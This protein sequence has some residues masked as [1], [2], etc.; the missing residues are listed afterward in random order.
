MTDTTFRS[1]LIKK[2]LEY[3]HDSLSKDL[4]LDDLILVINDFIYASVSVVHNKLSIHPVCLVNAVKNIIGENKNKP[5]KELLFFTLNYLF[6]HDFRIN[7]QDILDKV[8]EK[9]QRPIACMADLENACQNQ[10]WLEAELI[11][12]QI[13][14]ASDGSRAI[15]DL[16]AELALQNIPQNVLVVYHILRAYQ[17]QENKSDN[18]AFAKTMFNQ[19]S[20]Q[21][22]LNPHDRTD[23]T[24][25]KINPLML[26]SDDIILYSAISRIWSGDYVRISGYKRELSYWMS[27]IFANK[28]SKKKLSRYKNTSPSNSMSYSSIAEKIIHQKKSMDGKAID[29]VKLESIRGLSSLLTPDQ[30][31][32]LNKKYN[33]F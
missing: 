28:L 25:E 9:G 14:I 32:K 7:D 24:P 8:I 31:N 33:S 21:I 11:M 16:L 22:L 13:Y 15:F 5:S 1:N 30:I 23:M 10:E 18:W 26:E 17:F 19:I 3:C 2:N 20:G 4:Q 29:L 6:Q 27:E 12:A